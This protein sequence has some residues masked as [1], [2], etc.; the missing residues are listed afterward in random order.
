MEMQELLQSLQ[1]ELKTF[2]AKSQEEAK[3]IGAVSTETKAAIAAC[4][5][6]MDDMEVKAAKPVT[7]GGAS[8]TEEL[9]ANGDLDAMMRRGRGSVKFELSAK[10]AK[11]IMERKTVSVAGLGLGTPGVVPVE[12]DAGIVALAKP[13][14]RMRDVIPSRPTAAAEVYWVTESVRP[15]KASPVTEYTGLKPLAEPTFTVGKEPVQTIAL[16]CLA[17]NQILAD[18]AELE[19]FLRSEFAARVR[20]EEDRQI[21]FGDAT[22][23]ALNG[24][25]TQAQAWDL[26]LLTASDGY[27]YIDILAGARQQAAEDDEDVGS[28]FY[29]VHPGD[30][31]KIRRTKDTTGRYILGDPMSPFPPALW[32]APILDSTQMTKGYFLYGSGDARAGEIRDRQGLTVELSTEDSTNFRYNL[33][34]L[35]VE[36]RLALVIKRVNAFVFGSFSQSPA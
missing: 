25:T 3:A 12:R 35:R 7:G 32:G 1:T 6:R 26:T 11:D 24:I 23:P 10:S 33:V 8:L 28:P 13:I 4:I 20:E 30:L 14:L 34:T 15:T 9:K 2:I 17:S 29:V 18:Y 31:W 16:L 5:K 36:I 27:E 21:L 22:P 19:G